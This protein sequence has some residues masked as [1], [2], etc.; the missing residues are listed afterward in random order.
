[1]NECKIANTCILHKNDVIELLENLPKQY[2]TKFVLK[3]DYF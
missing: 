3:N 2:N 1:M